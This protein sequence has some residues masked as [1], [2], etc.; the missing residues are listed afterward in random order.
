MTDPNSPLERSIGLTGAVR[1]LL[2]VVAVI[3]IGAA[4][5]EGRYGLGIAGLVL[6]AVA[7]GA[8]LWIWRFRQDS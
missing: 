8:A 2:A 3:A 4:F 6:L 7:V 5:A 1:W